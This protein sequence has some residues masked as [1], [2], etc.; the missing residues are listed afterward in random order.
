MRKR[1]S[2]IIPGS[3]Y[4]CDF[5]NNRYWGGTFSQAAGVVYADLASDGGAYGSISA[6]NPFTPTKSGVLY[7]GKQSQNRITDLGLFAERASTNYC[8]WCRDLT[9]AAWTKTNCSAAKT[10]AGADGVASSASTITATGANATVYQTVT[11]NSRPYTAA[12]AVAGMGYVVNEV[13]TL[14]TAT[15]TAVSTAAKIK[16]LTVSGGV[17]QT[18]TVSSPLAYTVMPTNP[19]AQGSTT[20]SGTGLTVNLTFENFVLGAWVKRRTGTGTV[21]MTTDGGITPYDIT[22]QLSTT[23]Y[24]WITG[25]SQ[26]NGANTYSCGFMLASSGDAI[27]VDFSQFEPVAATNTSG[28]TV[29]VENPTGGMPTTPMLTTTVAAGR[30]NNTA[31]WQNTNV[32]GGTVGRGNDGQ[33]VINDVFSTGAPWSMIMSFNGDCTSNVNNGPVCLASDMVCPT[34]IGGGGGCPGAVGATTTANSGN[35]GRV[36]QGGAWNVIAF[37]CSGAGTSVCLNGGGIVTNTTPTTW[38][39]NKNAG[40]T[41][42][43]IGNNGSGTND[44]QLNGSIGKVEFL[45][46]EL[47]DAEMINYTAPQAR[48]G[49]Y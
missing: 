18:I 27:D 49:Q 40:C 4:S 2:W 43:N 7:Q 17:P 16:V 46:R 33:R 19:V 15:G 37:R 47:S 42:F 35:N 25:M 28:T 38:F 32:I 12:I 6:I 31:Y 34:S 44:T 13:D 11:P 5:I 1:P 26:T 39:P 41:H 29:T 48:Y 45:A 8:L 14:S 24:T 21:S 36:G 23:A 22:S 20:G 10:A 30:G 3:L 9:N